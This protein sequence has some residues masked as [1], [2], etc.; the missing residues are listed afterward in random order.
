MN[1]ENMKHLQNGI[2]L[3][4]QKTKLSN[5][6]VRMELQKNLPE[7]SHQD[8]KKDKYHT[9]TYTHASTHIYIYMCMFM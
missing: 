7:G 1:K 9:H 3:S 5:L 6:E 2:L 8:L 4:C